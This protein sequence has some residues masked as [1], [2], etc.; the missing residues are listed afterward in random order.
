MKKQFSLLLLSLLFLTACT[1][2]TGSTTEASTVDSANNSNVEEEKKVTYTGTIKTIADEMIY[3]D[4]LIPDEGADV[5]S[6]E[7]VVLLMN[8]DI[9]L[10]DVSGQ[11][12]HL[13][14]LTEGQTLEVVLAENAP[15]TKSLP[16]Q[17]AGIGI[18]SVT[19]IN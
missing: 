9:P 10:T 8:E 16:P 14:D 4:S 17:L 6:F 12:V 7:E 15:M 1:S 18:I 11:A 3:M 19:V 2:P 5:I 13:S